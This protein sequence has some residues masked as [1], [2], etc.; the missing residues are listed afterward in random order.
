VT[1]SSRTIA[2]LFAAAFLALHLPFPAASLEDLDSINFAL[3]VRDFDVARHQPHPPGY[4]LFIL[5]AKGVHAFVPSEVRTLSLLST[6]AAALAA[7]ALVELMR[8]I[9][10]VP[11][12]I[13]RAVLATLLTMTAPMYWFGASR[14]LSD[15]MGLAAAL[16]VQLAIVSAPTGTRVVWGAFL[17]AL[18][19]GIRSQVAWLTMPLLVLATMRQPRVVR[20]NVAIRAG[21]AIVAGVLVWFIPLVWLSGGPAIY[22]H[23]LSI[24]GAEDLAGVV[25][26]WTTPTPRQLLLALGSAFV[27]PWGTPA[28]ATVVLLL[29]VAGLVR[30][31]RASRAAVTTLAVAFGPYL[32][33]HMLFQETVTTRYALPLV[34][35]IAYL[36]VCGV[37]FL[38]ARLASSFV[39][40]A[41]VTGLA[42]AGIVLAAPALSA[43]SQI[44]APAFRM[45][46][47]MRVTVRPGKPPVLAM[48][49]LQTFSLRRP[50]DWIGE[51]M[52]PVAQRLPT[53]PKHEWLELVKYWNNGGRDVVWFVADPLR[54]DL[55]LFSRGRP[56]AYRWPFD[57]SAWIG[58]VRP[59]DMDWHVIERPEWYLGEGWAITPETAGVANED[60]RGPGREPIRGWVL[61]RPGPVHLMIGGRNLAGGGPPA[62]VRVAVDGRT[63]D[64]SMVPPGFFLRMLTLPAAGLAGEGD[65]STITVA[66]S[67]PGVAI[68]QFDAKPAGRVMFG[69]GDGWNEQEYEPA[70]GRLWRWMS[71]RGTLRVRAEGHALTLD[72]HGELEASS[73]SRITIRVGNRRV[74]EQDVGRSFSVRATIPG[75][76]VAEAES[77]ITI[78]TSEWYVPAERIGRSRDR[79]HLGLKIL[80]C[81]LTPAS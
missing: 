15:M 79:R 32:A 39:P 7:F 45:L 23:V 57:P 46:S 49:R 37:E 27:A 75:D 43:Y 13:R 16:A 62:S 35:P 58:G 10:P 3:G 29:A 11:Q 71:E 69:F 9:D 8:R 17:G 55:A 12:A 42:A 61:R 51:A 1:A 5:A 48:H 67:L 4:P 19:T 33:F 21:A 40:I 74:T 63:I 20:A 72:L 52:P 60:G 44:D 26:L 54:S 41:I 30:L 68:E 18:A 66:A 28:I 38:T 47:D 80:E 70:T 53:P 64:E 73:T 14:P 56:R 22:W 78:E 59:S 65:Y 24:Q 31:A 34:M 6:I 76:L 25:T 2:G 81:R 50:I 77:A 36:A